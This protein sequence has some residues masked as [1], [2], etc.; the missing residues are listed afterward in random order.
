MAIT[1]Y[2]S[3]SLLSSMIHPEAPRPT[4]AIH[5]QVQSQFGPVAAA[6]TVS[7]GHS[8][9][10]QLAVVVQLAEPQPTNRALDV[11]TGAGHT[12]L[13][14]APHVQE[15]VAYDLTPAMLEETRRN[16][17]QKGIT[18]LTLRQGAAEA[19]PFPD[20][21]FQIVTVRVASHH[22]ADNQAAVREMARVVCPGGRVII[23]DTTVPEEESL[24]QQI[25]A[26]EKLRDPSH[27]RNY[28]PSEWRAMV[29]E[30]GLQIT[31]LT[32]DS[33]TEGGHIDVNSWT[34]R[35]RTPADKVADIE[36]RFRSASLELIQA[37]D[38]R[39]EGDSIRFCLPKI[40]LVALK[41]Y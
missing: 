11:A 26:L 28:R 30:A 7:M 19:L 31:Y 10:E 6:Y 1:L 17:G 37:L 15:V 20:A 3:V 33:Y 32:V 9:P 2:E 25:N 39:L 4:Q 36:A 21:S 12:A 18:N 22:F 8:D 38:I 14:L 34:G 16:A 23:V 29:E 40:T 13:A 5:R 27:V 24:D 35:M 41:D